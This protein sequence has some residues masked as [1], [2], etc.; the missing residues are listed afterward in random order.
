ML[1]DTGCAR[2]GEHSLLTLALSPVAKEIE[3][4]LKGARSQAPS[5]SPTHC[6][7]PAAKERKETRAERNVLVPEPRY[8]R[9][10]CCEENV[11]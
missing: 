4:I 2:P 10:Y 6:C 1:T 7:P 11:S 8:R 9:E 5:F 3:R